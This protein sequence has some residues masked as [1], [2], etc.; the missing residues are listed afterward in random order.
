MLSLY[1]EI[2]FILKRWYKLK[3][4]LQQILWAVQFFWWG[5]KM[6]AFEWRWER[7]ECVNSSGGRRVLNVVTRD[8]FYPLVFQINIFIHQ[9]QKP[10]CEQCRAKP[11]YH[12]ALNELLSTILLLLFTDISCYFH[13]RFLLSYEASLCLLGL[14][15]NVEGSQKPLPW[16]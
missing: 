6:A 16:K 13:L 5:E 11:P 4:A 3:C 14:F 7:A 8:V 15:Q 9:N 2:P 1:I 12:S 10:L